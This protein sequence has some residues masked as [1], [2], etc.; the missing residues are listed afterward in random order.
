MHTYFQ[1]FAPILIYIKYI[2]M[3]SIRMDKLIW[4]LF[5]TKLA[6]HE[7]YNFM[8]SKSK[9]NFNWEVFICYFHRSFFVVSIKFHVIIKLLERKNLDSFLYFLYLKNTFC[10]SETIRQVSKHWY[11]NSNLDDREVNSCREVDS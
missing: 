11:K 3:S 1:Y 6:T 9:S 4:N 10:V 8:H 7:C 5:G 2:S